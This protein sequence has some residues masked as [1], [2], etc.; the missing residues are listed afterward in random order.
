MKSIEV[1]IY[2]L[3]AIGVISALIAFIKTPA[4]QRYGLTRTT[5]EN[6]PNYAPEHTKQERIKL[7]I[8]SASWALPLYICL[9]Y[10]FFPWLEKYA[11]NARCYDYGTFTGLHVLYYGIFIGMP[12][13]F[14]VI[15]F[16]IEGPKNIQIIRLGQYPMPG[17]KVLSP[18][19]YVYGLRAKS[20]AILFFGILFFL[21][22]LSIRGY[23]WAKDIIDIPIKH[24]S[25]CADS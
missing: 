13:S 17:E 15:L 14:A 16:A 5:T 25:T 21:V 22:G 4:E 23:Y 18:T 24:K 19:K 9:R 6:D 1:V 8:K 11:S 12:L 7:V 2:A 20:I 3:A 10:W